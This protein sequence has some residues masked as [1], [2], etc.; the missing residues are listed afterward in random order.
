MS[1]NRFPFREI[2]P[3]VFVHIRNETVGRKLDSR[4]FIERSMWLIFYIFVQTI[5][6]RFQKEEPNSFSD[7]VMDEMEE[8]DD[9]HCART[10]AFVPSSKRLRIK[11]EPLESKPFESE[12][13]V[14]KSETKS[15]KY[16]HTNRPVPLAKTNIEK[17]STIHRLDNSYHHMLSNPRSIVSKR[18]KIIN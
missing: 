12:I 2:L 7:M 14:E 5:E 6:S 17:H 15:R 8:Q 10:R 4:L 1:E 3:V 11:S 13:E 18:K 16:W 9:G